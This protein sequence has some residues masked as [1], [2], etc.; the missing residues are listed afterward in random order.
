MGLVTLSAAASAGTLQLPSGLPAAGKLSPPP[1]LLLEELP[2]PLLDEELL[3]NDEELLLAGLDEPPPPLPPQASRIE[4]RRA[5]TSRRVRMADSKFVR[6][7]TLRELLRVGQVFSGG[8][9]HAPP[10]G[11]GGTSG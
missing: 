6:C 2:E 10:D 3:L 4:L 7:V 8:R 1:E 11:R 9:G 5:G